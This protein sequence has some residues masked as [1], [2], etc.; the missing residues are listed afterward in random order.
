MNRRVQWGCRGSKRGTGDLECI[1]RLF[2]TAVKHRE[3][4][5]ALSFAIPAI[6]LASDPRTTMRASHVPQ[7]PLLSGRK[8][9]PG[10]GKDLDRMLLELG[11]TV[12]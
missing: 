8:L 10:T 9:K 4:C 5:T 3:I 2:L 7:S 12:G 6:L 1:R 11:G